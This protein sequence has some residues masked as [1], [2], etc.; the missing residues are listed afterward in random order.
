MTSHANIFYCEQF[1]V[2]SSQKKQLRVVLGGLSEN[3]VWVFEM[4]EIFFMTAYNGCNL[5]QWHVGHAVDF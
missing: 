4:I 3:A 2:T 1:E 5:L